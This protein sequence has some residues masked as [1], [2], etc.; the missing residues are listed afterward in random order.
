MKRPK[1]EP[2]ERKR[3]K[4]VVRLEDLTPREAVQ[5]GASK[6]RFG[7]Q[8]PGRRSPGSRR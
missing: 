6:L 8:R 5:G 1:R 7:E 3:K 2:Q 4:D